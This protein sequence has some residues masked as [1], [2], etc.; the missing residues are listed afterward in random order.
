MKTL[1]LTTSSLEEIDAYTS[2]FIENTF[3]YVVPQ[4]VFG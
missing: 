4:D 1:W 3:G 2:D